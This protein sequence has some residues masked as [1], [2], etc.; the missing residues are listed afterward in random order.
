MGFNPK[1]FNLFQLLE[2]IHQQTKTTYRRASATS[3]FQMA[4]QAD[5]FSPL[6]AVGCY[7]YVFIHRPHD[8]N[9]LYKRLYVKG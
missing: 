2:F 9:I 4:K 7:P 3:A 1:S 6:Y 8:N 5:T